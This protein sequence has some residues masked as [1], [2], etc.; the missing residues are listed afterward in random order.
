MAKQFYGTL[1]RGSTGSWVTSLEYAMHI[2]NLYSGG[3]DGEFGGG[4]EQ[5]VKNFQNKAGLYADGAVGVNTWSSIYARIQPLQHWL[6]CEK[7]IYCADDGIAGP[8]TLNAI[9]EF[10]R[11]HGLTPDGYVGPATMDALGI[12]FWY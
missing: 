2:F 12:N 10:Q 3:F 8:G 5:A 7:H 4:L 6:S 9:E 11:Q 1:K